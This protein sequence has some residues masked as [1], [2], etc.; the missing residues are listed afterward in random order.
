[1]ALV[2]VEGTSCGGCHRVFPPQVI[3]EVQIQDKVV[4]CEFC[5]RL[6]YWPDFQS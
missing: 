5:A 3:N 2:P 4:R 1:L 6:L